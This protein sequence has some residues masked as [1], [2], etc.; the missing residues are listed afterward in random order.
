MEMLCEKGW[1]LDPEFGEAVCPARALEIG[2]ADGGLLRLTL[3]DT[4]GVVHTADVH[5]R[6]VG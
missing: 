2:L 5:I 6:S 4:D 3:T 1:E